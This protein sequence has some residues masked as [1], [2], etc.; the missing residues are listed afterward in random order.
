MGNVYL[1][2]LDKDTWEK[3]NTCDLVTMNARKNPDLVT[4]LIAD[5]ALPI[6]HRLI[7]QWLKVGRY[8]PK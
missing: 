5:F 7:G 6:Y 1:L 3:Y 2:G 4:R 8:Q